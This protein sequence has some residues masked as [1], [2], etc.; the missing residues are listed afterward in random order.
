MGRSQLL[1]CNGSHCRKARRK[2]GRLD[3]AVARMPVDVAYVRCQK[4]CR[5]P[6]VGL[7]LDG[8]WQWFER[9]DS[10]KALRALA[11]AV[12]GGA[13]AKPLRKRRDRKRAGRLRT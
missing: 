8:E 12:D 13:L 9:M 10:R 4:V 5:A 2:D 1:V 7:S 6:V 3:A 11:A